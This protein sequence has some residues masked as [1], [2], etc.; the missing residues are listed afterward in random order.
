MNTKTIQWLL[1][2]EFWEYRGSMLW[3]PAVV[4]LLIVLLVGGTMAYGILGN[5]M[6]THITINGAAVD[7]VRVSATLPLETKAMIARVATS[8]YLGAS[9]PLFLILAAVVFSYCLGALYDERRDR[10]ILFWKSLPVSDQMT[11][12]SKAATAMVLA[13]LV[14]IA[15]ASVASLVLLLVICVV[16]SLHGINV[17]GAVLASPDLYLAPLRLVSMLPVYVVWALPTVGWLLLVSSWARTKPFLWAVGIPV[18][19]L[20]LLKWISAAMLASSGEELAILPAAKSIV[21]R[22]LSGV[23]PGIWYTYTGMPAIP[24]PTEHGIDAN[25]I[26]ASSYATLAGASAWIGAAMGAAMLFAATRM[27]RWRDEG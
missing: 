15:V 19:S 5:H 23:M 10:S 16:L 1:R 18:V 14:T 25:A 22:L 12:L 7:G 13:P 24:R 3:A 21:A 20:V 6:P 4:G 17:F 27:R 2:R 26:V 11:V 9:A 8:M